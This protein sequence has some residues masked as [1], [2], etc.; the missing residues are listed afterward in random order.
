MAKGGHLRFVTN[1]QYCTKCILLFGLRKAVSKRRSCCAPANTGYAD[2]LA[3]SLDNVPDLCRASVVSTSLRGSV[4]T[5]LAFEGDAS[6][7]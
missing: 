1:R 4:P 3:S 2:A 6:Y 7:V 5:S